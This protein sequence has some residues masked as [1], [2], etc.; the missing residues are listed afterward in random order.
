M[1]RTTRPIRLEVLEDR[2]LLNA[3]PELI[4]NDFLGDEIV[5]IGDTAFF[6]G[7]PRFDGE[8]WKSDG[9]SDGTMLVKDIRSGE[10]SSSPR[11]LTNVNG[12]LFFSADDG[13]HGHE[14]WKSD[15]TNEG[16][17]LVK[18]ILPGTSGSLP[19]SLTNLNGTLVFSANLHTELWRS[20][21]TQD[22]TV[23][24]K[25][26]SKSLLNFTNLD[27]T[28]FFTA[29]DGTRGI[30]LWKSDGTSDG[31]MLVKDIRPGESSSSPRELTNVNGK[32]FF[33]AFDGN[34]G[35]ELWKSD[36]TSAGTVLVKDIRPG[37]FGSYANDLTNV[38]G[39]LFFSA[40]DRAHGYE[41]WKSD[42]TAEG[43]LLVKD[44]YPGE[45]SSFP[46]NLTNVS[47]TLFFSANDGYGRELWK[48]DGTEAGT[49]LVKD[50]N[51]KGGSNPGA[52]TAF[53]DN[54]LFTAYDRNYGLE[55]WLS[56]GTADGTMIIGDL[57]PEDL[58]AFDT[59]LFELIPAGQSFYF[60]KTHYDQGNQELIDDLYSFGPLV[61]GTS[62]HDRISIKVKNHI[63]VTINGQRQSF[64][65]KELTIMGLG[66]NDSLIIDGTYGDDSLVA[67]PTS[68][69]FS[70]DAF[71]IHGNGTANLIVRGNGGTDTAILLDS[72]GDERVVAKP[73]NTFVRN[74]AG[75][76]SHR[77]TNFR[78]VTLRS[79]GVQSGNFDLA[80]LFDTANS[81]TF[82]GNPNDAT[83]Y[84]PGYRVR[85]EG[86][87]RSVARSTQGGNDSAILNGSSLGSENFT[88]RVTNDPTKN[89]GMFRSGP[90][91]SIAFLNRAIGFKRVTG[92]S[93]RGDDKAFFFDGK[94]D[95]I[96]FA[97]ANFARLRGEGYQFV[98][99]KF[100]RTTSNANAGGTDRATLVDGLGDD[101]LFGTKTVA[102]LIGESSRFTNSTRGF[103]KV[104]GNASQGGND[105][106]ELASDIAFQFFEQGS[107]EL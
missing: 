105:K 73:G 64:A 4:E 37:V 55:F 79:T 40:S 22:G 23:L 72:A 30:E 87:D 49:V 12:T 104:T 58:D 20:D 98:A 47:G 52:M 19:H 107:W 77:V 91:A 8:L 15:G 7:G 45:R 59:D 26:F 33:T 82:I 60:I 36:G 13:T 99:N 83:I 75:T 9:T 96:L 5:F 25:S 85:T 101:K 29:D 6:R 48:S 97:D 46:A 42:G 95:D 103:E 67:M 10:S 80:N 63:V 89:F 61:A 24:V 17:A 43:T 69:E 86:Y 3:S 31:T 92:N 94:G 62:G 35:R 32:V 14:L 78:D 53:N 81:D 56:D 76:F 16:T 100:Q 44:I 70:G 41:L 18:D 51:G 90:G 68:F 38:N 71:C 54:L 28:L 50:I 106:L 39:T 102:T 66:G 74:L 88:A 27:G 1:S 21:G 57:L 11:E 93:K 2:T 65:S 84:S 34:S